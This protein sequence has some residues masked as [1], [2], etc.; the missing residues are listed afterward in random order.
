MRAVWK[1]EI[2]TRAG[3][4]D[5]K[6]PVGAQIVHVGHQSLDPS[7]VTFWA[8][9]DLDAPRI[10]RTFAIYGTGHQIGRGM[11]RGTALV[12]SRLVWHLYEVTS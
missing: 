2:D 3:D 10:T 7:I 8:E 4:T 12:S 5:V 11:Y 9:V 1:Y 6:I